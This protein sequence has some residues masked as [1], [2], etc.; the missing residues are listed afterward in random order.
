MYSNC[1]EPALSKI[2]EVPLSLDPS[3]YGKEL[4]R[5]ND[6]LDKDLNMFTDSSEYMNLLNR[7]EALL[8]L[9]AIA[10]SF[11]RVTD[12]IND[13]RHRIADAPLLFFHED[14]YLSTTHSLLLTISSVVENTYRSYGNAYIDRKY[15][16]VD[17]YSINL[18]DLVSTGITLDNAIAQL[19]RQSNAQPNLIQRII[20]L[21]RKW[22][23]NRLMKSTARSNKSKARPKKSPASIALKELEEFPKSSTCNDSPQPLATSTSVPF[24]RPNPEEKKIDDRFGD[25]PG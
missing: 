22:K 24:V 15:E 19:K 10:T 6:A 3:A 9:Q 14:E 4:D 25:Q 1:V 12:A 23:S 20:F 5:I 17:A 21:R 7:T 2:K 18:H 8:R 11:P 13:V 16:T